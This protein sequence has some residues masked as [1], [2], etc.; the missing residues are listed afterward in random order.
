MKKS[1]DFSLSGILLIPEHCQE[2]KV[3]EVIKFETNLR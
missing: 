3:L 2:H 1:L